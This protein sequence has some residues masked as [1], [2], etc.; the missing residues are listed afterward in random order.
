[1]T[2]CHL[3]NI[4]ALGSSALI[5]IDHI[6][7]T[8]MSGRLSKIMSSLTLSD[9]DDTDSVLLASSYSAIWAGMLSSTAA[10]I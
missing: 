5:G 2:Y 3:Y 1:M 4:I 6:L 10:H 8:V 9:A 7:G